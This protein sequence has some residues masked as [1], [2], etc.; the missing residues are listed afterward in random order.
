ME[1]EAGR[2]IRNTNVTL[3]IW[4]DK[5]P[6]YFGKKDKDTIRSVYCWPHLIQRM[7]WGNA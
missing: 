6:E 1:I 2:D 4:T 7:L 5:I 3:K